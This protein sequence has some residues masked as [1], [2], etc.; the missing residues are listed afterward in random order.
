MCAA[1]MLVLLSSFLV[2]CGVPVAGAISQIRTERTLD[3][4][5]PHD[6]E[7]RVASHWW[8]YKSRSSDPYCQISSLPVLTIVTSPRN[9]TTRFATAN[10]K[11]GNCLNEIEGTVVMYKPN[12]GFIG[13]D[14]FV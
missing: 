8:S 4:K 5:V 7:S 6:Q 12:P 13:Q 10:V 14:Q 9:G 3:R 1:R 11:P 2:V